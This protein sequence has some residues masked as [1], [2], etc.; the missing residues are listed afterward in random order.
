[1]DFINFQYIFLSNLKKQ[2]RKKCINL[3]N[4]HETLIKLNLGTSSENIKAFVNEL[5]AI[6]I[7]NK[8]CS[9]KLYENILL[10][11]L[12]TNVLS[13]FRKSDILI[14]ACKER[15]IELMKWLLNMKVDLCIQ[16]EYG[17]TALMYIVK[18]PILS[19][20]IKE[21]I[22]I[23]KNCVNMID[24]KG[25]TAMFYAA[26]NPEI[27]RAII[28]SNIDINHKD[29]EGN[30]IICYCS[31]YGIFESFLIIL[32][33]SNVDILAEN[34]EG[35]NTVIYLIEK[36][37][38]WELKQYAKRPQGKIYLKKNNG[39]VI[40]TLIKQIYQPEKKHHPNYYI[41]YYETLNVLINMDYDFNV[42]IDE[43][44]NTPLMFFIMIEDFCT[45]YKMVKKCTKLDYSLKNIHG[46]NTLSLCLKLKNKHLINFI[47]D[48]KSLDFKYNDKL[49]NNILI[50]YII[51]DEHRLL[52]NVLHRNISLLNQ[53]NDNKET[54]LIIAT[55]L[56][57]K[58][59]VRTLLR[60]GAEVNHQDYLGNT[61]SYYAVDLHDKFMVSAL[62]FYKADFNIKNNRGKSTWDLIHEIQDEEIMDVINNPVPT[63]VTYNDSKDTNMLSQHNIKVKKPKSSSSL[64]K[65]MSQSMKSI[66]HH[67]RH[68]SHSHSSDTD[69]TYSNSVYSIDVHNIN[70]KK[71]QSNI[72]FKMDDHEYSYHPLPFNDIIRIIELDIYDYNHKDINRMKIIGISYEVYYRTIIFRTMYYFYGLILSILLV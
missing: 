48:Q 62:T 33:S 1:M 41:P 13:E 24:K 55:K 38:H 56:G 6:I 14:K 9:F 70:H 5:N 15:N 39:L 68:H 18:I 44:G 57:R 36:G 16:D 3:I 17:K 30:N 26:K 28:N 32:W 64:S 43:N 20:F 11:E 72:E 71:Y 46:D 35:K 34:N 22:R 7:Q 58:K 42:A 25:R 65:K 21:M 27:F 61:A 40:K 67:I 45:V 19:S 50:Y 31:K 63:L 10:H 29:N 53:M 54:P 59:I 52:R 69:S 8:V 37:R 49:N 60:M 51:I 47:Y 12:F 23:D 2:K 4:N 66:S